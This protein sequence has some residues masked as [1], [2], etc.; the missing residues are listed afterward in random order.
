MHGNYCTTR[1][2][3]G[4][5]MLIS[6]F[7]MLAIV[8]AGLTM[9]TLVRYQVVQTRNQDNAIRARY[10]AE[11]GVERGLDV[12]TAHR[13]QTQTGT[14]TDLTDTLNLVTALTGSL[15]S[16]QGSYT[17][18]ATRTSEEVTGVQFSL[19]QFS[20]EQIDL[21]DVEQPY[22]ANPNPVESLSVDWIEGDACAAGTSV[23]EVTVTQ[24]D[25]SG[26]AVDL[27]P[28]ELVTQCGSF[29][30]ITGFD[31]RMETNLPVSPNNYV[32]RIKA[33]TCDVEYGE[34]TAYTADGAAAGT[35]QN[36]SSHAVITVNGT[37]GRSQAALQASAPWRAA[38]SGFTDYVLFVEGDLVK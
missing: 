38:P 23:L 37:Y 18:D 33:R 25:L 16:G 31:C 20:S 27:V 11:S 36:L 35:E 17:F 5:I 24:F 26:A 34:F 13:L 6:V 30:P 28:Q 7:I 14:P 12:L 21:F 8:G 22:V 10:S 32:V 1:H 4:S 9:A 29:P 2:P 15:Y 19:A 3:Q